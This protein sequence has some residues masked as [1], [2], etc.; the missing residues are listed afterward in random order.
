ME[1]EASNESGVI[2]AWAREL[3]FGAWNFYDLH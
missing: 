1:A 2:S 3:S